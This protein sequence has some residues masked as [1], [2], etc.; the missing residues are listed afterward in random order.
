VSE[1]GTRS[2]IDAALL[3]VVKPLIVKNAMLT[4]QFIAQ[5]N[6]AKLRRHQRVN[7]KIA[8]DQPLYFITIVMSE[9]IGSM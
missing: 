8:S 1:S 7:V 6:A 9:I 3:P 4:M 2:L 5:L